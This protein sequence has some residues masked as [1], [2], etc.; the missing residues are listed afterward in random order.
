MERKIAGILVMAM[1]ALGFAGCGQ[2]GDDPDKETKKLQSVTLSMWGAKE[3]QEMLRE[4]ADA[5]VEEYKETAKF[6]IQVGV[7]SESDALDNVTADI[8]AAPDVYAFAGD[9]IEELVQQGALQE[10]T[11]NTDEII[12]ANGGSE[13]AAV[14][15]ATVEGRLYGCP[16]AADNGY[17]MY[18]NKEYFKDADL[19]T[20]E[21]MLDVAED[22]HKKVAMDMKN[23]WYLYAFFGGDA[24]FSLVKK[25]DMTNAC[26]FNGES[27]R[28]IRGADVL[29]SILAICAHEGFASMDDEEF[30]EGVKDG[31]VI[32][33]VDGTWA[34]ADVKEAWGD[35]YGACKLPAYTCVEKELQMGSFAGYKMVGVNP[36]SDYV[37]YAML[38][39]DWVTNQENQEKRF[40]E[41]SASPTNV[42]A[43]SSEKVKTDV[44]MAAVTEQNQYATLDG[45]ESENYWEPMEALGTLCV[46]G[47]PE[48]RDLQQALDE[49]VSEITKPLTKEE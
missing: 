34:A 14:R 37:G 48:G 23:G 16:M 27:P 21:Q 49:T 2:K 7:C 38:L 40:E 32:A 4:M 25:D 30:R 17:F 33:G 46:E 24:G 44:T 10:I 41:R 39:A 29:Q 11:I 19:E 43:A 1:F 31:T 35:Q 9:Q 20:I 5:F 22:F 3:D 26:D 8:P 6:D 45:C 28:G 15:A 47:N 13:S 36:Y 18:Y 42:E 12:R